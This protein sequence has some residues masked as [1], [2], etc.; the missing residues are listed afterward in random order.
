[1]NDSIFYNGA[2]WPVHN[3]P[4]IEYLAS[5]YK[6]LSHIG[7][8]TGEPPVGLYCYGHLENFMNPKLVWYSEEDETF[9]RQT[10]TLI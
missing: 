2:F 3:L 6:K 8:A 10:V 1:M 5:E 9:Y 7:M 4:H